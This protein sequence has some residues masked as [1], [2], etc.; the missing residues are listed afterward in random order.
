MRGSSLY[1][2][3]RRLPMR[4]LTF[5]VAKLAGTVERVLTASHV[6]SINNHAHC[7]PQRVRHAQLGWRRF[8]HNLVRS[9]VQRND[10]AVLVVQNDTVAHA[11]GSEVVED[12]GASVVSV[13]G[14]NSFT[15]GLSH[16]W[17]RYVH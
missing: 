12:G 15:V 5:D 1:T 16:Y 11:T 2:H 13:S 4:A 7:L 8:A 17:Q 6:C 3:T 10:K 9:A 14:R